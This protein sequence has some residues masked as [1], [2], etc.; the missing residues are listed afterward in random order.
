MTIDEVTIPR[1]TLIT[2]THSRFGDRGRVLDI[3]SVPDD[4]LCR[5]LTTFSKSNTHI[6]NTDELLRAKKQELPFNYP[7]IIGL[8]VAK[9]CGSSSWAWCVGEINKVESNLLFG[10]LGIKFK[11]IHSSIQHDLVIYRID[12]KDIDPRS[13]WPSY[14]GEYGFR[15]F[16]F[17]KTETELEKLILQLEKS[18]NQDSAIALKLWSNIRKL[19]NYRKSLTE[20]CS[21]AI[22]CVLTDGPYYNH[23]AINSSKLDVDEITLV[24]RETCRTYGIDCPVIPN[25]DMQYKILFDI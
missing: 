23:V 24:I 3:N 10:E 11:K 13:I 16:G 8:C 18:F 12:C 9:L 20:L 14:T 22:I 1:M 21:D 25:T 17:D 15:I 6:S 2:E 4:K 5:V 19:C 7:K